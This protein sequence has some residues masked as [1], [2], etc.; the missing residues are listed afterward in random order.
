MV[1]GNYSPQSVRGYMME[2]RKQP[3]SKLTV[4]VATLMM[5][6]HGVDLA[7]CPKCKTNNMETVAT[8]RRGVLCA[9]LA[10]KADY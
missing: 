5:E 8:Y 9:I 2:L 6:K 1:V 10:P 3:P 7:L 4:L